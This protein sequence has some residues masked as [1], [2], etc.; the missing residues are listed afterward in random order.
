MRECW[1]TYVKI[2][3]S[4]A[5]ARLEEVDRKVIN[6]L[7]FSRKEGFF[8]ARAPLLESL[9]DVYTRSDGEG[10]PGRDVRNALAL[11]RLPPA[12]KSRVAA[13]SGSQRGSASPSQ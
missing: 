7:T 13:A 2:S 12:V 1:Q 4:S 9:D 6:F 3:S 11:F 10:L 5:D 8:S